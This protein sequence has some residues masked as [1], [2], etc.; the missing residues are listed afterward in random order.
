MSFDKA[1]DH[2]EEPILGS[3]KD[4]IDNYV[5]HEKGPRIWGSVKKKKKK[6]S[7]VTNCPLSLTKH[8]IMARHQS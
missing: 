6:K 5:E 1:P 4:S 3:T 8:Q 2:G 7:K